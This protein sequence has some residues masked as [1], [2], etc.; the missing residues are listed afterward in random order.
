MLYRHPGPHEIHCDKFD[1]VIVPGDQVE[2][3]IAAGWYRTTGE[4]KVASQK[5]ADKPAE[6]L[7]AK[8]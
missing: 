7:V 4:A 8:K 1:Y 2:K 6:R 5:A 3:T